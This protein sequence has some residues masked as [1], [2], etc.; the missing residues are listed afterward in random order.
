MEQRSYVV[1][2]ANDGIRIDK[3]LALLMEECSRSYIQKIIG[4]QSVCV[5]GKAVKANFKIHTGDAVVIELPDP[6]ILDIQPENI[7]LDI[8]YEDQDILAV[9]KPAGLVTHPSGIHYQDSLSN[10][11]AQYFRSKGEGTRIRSIGRLD[12]ETSG[13]L[14]FARNQISAARL[15]KQREEGKL[16]KTY[17]A[18]VEGT[19]ENKES[20]ISIPL[21]PDPK[22]HL[23]MVLS[24]DGT[25]PGSKAAV[26]CY[27]VLESYDNASLVQLQLKTGRTHQ[28]RVHM[29]GTG[30]PLLGDR[31]YNKRTGKAERK[32]VTGD[33]F[34]RAALHGWKL[35]FYHPFTGKKILLEAPLPQDFEHFLEKR[36]SFYRK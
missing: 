36:K 30:H 26:T 15:Q 27:K 29:A 3:Y 22:N 31:L 19:F 12:K 4:D 20:E 13:I 23:Q 16:R 8:L 32:S 34:T 24:F 5:N 2:E 7:P 10:L 28:I 14:L 9:N 17:L 6:V 1:D 33:F 11:I 35:V 21:A 25:L 18:A